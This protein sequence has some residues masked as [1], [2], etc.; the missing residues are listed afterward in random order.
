MAWDANARILIDSDSII[1]LEYADKNLDRCVIQ[2][3][4]KNTYAQ[5]I[6]LYPAVNEKAQYR[7]GDTLI[8]GNDIKENGIFIKSLK[9]NSCQILKL[10]KT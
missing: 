4:T 6:V 2:L 8:F 1:V 9:D 3:F 10:S 5:G 7:C